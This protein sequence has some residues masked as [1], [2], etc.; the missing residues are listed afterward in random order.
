MIEG[1]AV[2]FLN[3]EGQDA[4]FLLIFGLKLQATGGQG[5]LQGTTSRKKSNDDFNGLVHRGG[6]AN[7][8]ATKQKENNPLPNNDKL[9]KDFAKSTLFECIE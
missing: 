5:V 6:S 1:G 9:T 2:S 4:S 8:F 3:G 7:V